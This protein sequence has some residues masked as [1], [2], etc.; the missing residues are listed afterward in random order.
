[1]IGYYINLTERV[2]RRNHF[3]K[4][5]TKYDFLKNIERI[6]A[7]KHSN[8]SIGCGLSHIMA[9]KK[10]KEK[11]IQDSLKFVCVFE[12]DFCI[13][14][15]NN[16]IKFIYDFKEIQDNKDW[17]LIVLT[18]RGNTNPDESINNFKRI[19]NNQTATAYIIKTS[20][21]DILITN[22]S[23]AV[24]GLQYN[25]NPNEYAIDQYWKKIQEKYKFYYYYDIFAGQL[26]GFSSIE[27]KNVNYNH[28]FITQQKY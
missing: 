20:M 25:Y 28:R 6:E 12:D 8:G 13:L 5:K 18:P 7:I 14:N 26:P 23:E 10:L 1:M 16:F 19:K 27:K 3:E 2:D 21:I 22:L 15:N 9:L 17:D 11:A 4:L 24:Q